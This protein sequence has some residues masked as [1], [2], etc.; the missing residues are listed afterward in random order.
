MKVPAGKKLALRGSFLLLALL[1]FGLIIKLNIT[2]LSPY[3]WKKGAVKAENLY[4]RSWELSGDVGA[5]DPVIIKEGNRWYI[6]Y[7]GVGLKMKYSDDGSHWTDYGGIFNMNPRWFKEYVPNAGESIWAPDI[8]Y[9]KGTYYLYYSVS[10]FGKNTSVIGLA[11]NKTLD[12][13]S[14]DYEWKDLGAVISSDSSKDYNCIDPNMI[15]D[16]DGQPWLSFGS[17]W[18]GIKMVKLDPATMKPAPDPQLHAIAARPGN[19]AIE[20]PHIV[21]RDGWYYHFIS[22]DF[23]CKKADSNYKIMAGRSK[24]I[25]GPYLDKEGKSMLE[26]GGT[27]IDAGDNRWK[28]PGHCAVYLSGESAILVNHAYDALNNGTATLQIRPLYWDEEGWPYLDAGK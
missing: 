4:D 12:P 8:S 3:V 17:F 28:G 5:H 11:S 24:S 26:G 10:T 27:L 22:F 19:T 14:P 23:C 21:Y 13:D 25:T 7:T 20:A 16:K 15:V 1:L 2:E 6:F 18:S 9:Y